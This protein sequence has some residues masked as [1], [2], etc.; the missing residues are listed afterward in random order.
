MLPAAS[1]EVVFPQWEEFL[2][3]GWGYTDVSGETP[4]N[5]L[6]EV[7]HST[8][9]A[10]ALLYSK[11]PA[12]CCCPDRHYTAVVAYGMHMPLPLDRQC[13]PWQRYERS[14]MPTPCRSTWHFWPPAPASC[15]QSMAAEAGQTRSPRRR[16]Q[17]LT[18]GRR[19][20]YFA[21]GTQASRKAHWLSSGGCASFPSLRVGTPL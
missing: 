11:Q 1:V 4:A 7:G 8:A 9:D 5:E 12:V 18:T 13:C 14:L 2:A 3:A 6:Q 21:C 16:T 19:T 17:C 20:T 10:A 15:K